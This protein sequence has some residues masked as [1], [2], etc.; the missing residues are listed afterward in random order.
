MRSLFGYWIFPKMC[1]QNKLWCFLT[2]YFEWFVEL[3]NMNSGVWMGD[4]VLVTW[5]AKK[6]VWSVCPHNSVWSVDWSS[7]KEVSKHTHT[8]NLIFHCLCQW[9]SLH[10]NLAQLMLWPET[11]HC[12]MS[13]SEMTPSGGDEPSQGTATVN[14]RFVLTE[15]PLLWS[16]L[17][18]TLLAA[19]CY[20]F[21]F[22]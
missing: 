19:D 21:L 9:I 20:F 13:F 16:S 10:F 3:I 15:S 6:R 18:W 22:Y 14:H 12:R 5:K 8:H 4:R 7:C 11:H 17:R 2:V 1:F